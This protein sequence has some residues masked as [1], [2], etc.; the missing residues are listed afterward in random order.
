MFEMTTLSI[1]GV[2]P[3]RPLMSS[4]EIS[5]LTGKRHSDILRDIRSVL[6]L[7]ASCRWQG[8]KPFSWTPFA[9]L[10]MSFMG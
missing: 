1:P 6:I 2:L 4:K 10:L 5:K 3:D 8:Q 9:A 7:S